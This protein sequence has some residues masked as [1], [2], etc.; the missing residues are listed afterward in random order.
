M[1]ERLLAWWHQRRYVWFDEA[2][3]HRAK[4]AYDIA[5]VLVLLL[6]A[7]TIAN[8]YLSPDVVDDGFTV[9]QY[10]HLCSAFFCFFAMG[11]S[12]GLMHLRDI[13][14]EEDK[15]EREAKGR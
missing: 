3:Q 9:G 8:A 7:I 11:L 12:Y 6:A 13:L 14:R 15:E 1:I 2:R 10:V 4:R 5:F